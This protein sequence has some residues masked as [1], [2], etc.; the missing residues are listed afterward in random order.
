ME[1]TKSKFERAPRVRKKYLPL[2]AGIVW[3]IA[4]SAVLAI[5][6]P[7]LVSGWQVPWLS[8]LIAAVIFG[9]FFKFVFF[10]LFKKHIARIEA[11]PQE[12]I[13]AFAFFDVKGYIVMACMITFG[14]VV[15]SVGILPPVY[16]GMLYTGLGFAMLGAAAAFIITFLKKHAQDA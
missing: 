13:C 8:I 2:F 9:L 5:G 15:R 7:A 16:L 4:G 12:K 6:L 1:D 10:R 14:I 3:G 11:F